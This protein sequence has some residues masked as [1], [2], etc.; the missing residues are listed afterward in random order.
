MNK[1]AKID[2]S[3]ILK[4]I[5]L[6]AKKTSESKKVN[7][8]KIEKT[9]NVKLSVAK[10]P[11]FNFRLFKIKKLNSYFPE[12]KVNKIAFKDIKCENTPNSLFEKNRVNI[13]IAII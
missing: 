9:R 10:N 11:F 1:L 6:L 12:I 5:H 3:N 8:N 2:K 4:E 7:N 13:G